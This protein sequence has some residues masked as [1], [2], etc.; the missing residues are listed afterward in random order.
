[1]EEHGLVQIFEY[2]DVD[3]SGDVIMSEYENIYR[4]QQVQNAERA[5]AQERSGKHQERQLQQYHTQPAAPAGSTHKPPAVYAPGE[6]DYTLAAATAPD[7][8]ASAPGIY[9]ATPVDEPAI[10]EPVVHHKSFTAKQ[11]QIKKAIPEPSQSISDAMVTAPRDNNAAKSEMQDR[12]FDL[13]DTNADN[14]VTLAE[15]LAGNGHTAGEAQRA[16][17]TFNSLDTNGDMLLSREEFEKSANK[18]HS[19]RDRNVDIHGA[20]EHVVMNKH[21]SKVDVNA[22]GFLSHEEIRKHLAKQLGNANAIILL[23]DKDHDGRLSPAEYEQLYYSPTSRVRQLAHF[24]STDTNKDDHLS[25]DEFLANATAPAARSLRRL[26]FHELDKNIDGKITFEE[27]YTLDQNPSLRSA[28]HAQAAIGPDERHG[29]DE[30]HFDFDQF[31]KNGDSYLDK[32]EVA[33]AA[34]PQKCDTDGDHL[35]SLEEYLK[36]FEPDG[37]LEEHKEEYINMDENRDGKVDRSEFLKH[38]PPE[39]GVSET[40]YFRTTDKDK[41]GWLSFDEVF[42]GTSEPHWSPPVHR[43]ESV[44]YKPPEEADDSPDAIYAENQHNFKVLDANG[45]GRV[46]ETELLT[47]I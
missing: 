32:D 25:L 12:S 31:D 37:A 39:P 29:N 47:H 35:V 1:M 18:M 27:M 4:R 28:P 44:W 17:A 16:R 21:F 34:L 7:V 2:L 8:G 6:D 45:D 40:V 36:L 9:E 26:E 13:F 38:V 33:A 42:P 19:S 41:N 11:K 23:A 20:D 30:L 3:H 5:N 24:A 43:K 46:N 10:N 22:D 15:F 14:K